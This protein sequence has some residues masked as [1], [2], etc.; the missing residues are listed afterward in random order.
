MSV[1]P[2][3]SPSNSTGSGQAASPE[4]VLEIDASCRAPVLLLFVSALVWLFVGSIFGIIATL[5]FHN[6]N[7][8]A[9][10]AWLTYGRVH[11]AHMNALVYGFA[12]QAGLGVALWLVAHLGRT[13]LAFGPAIMFGAKLWNLGMTLGILGILYGEST[14]YE[15]LEMP[16]YASAF[17]FCGYVLMALG[18]LLTLHQRREGSL[19]ISQTFV[20]AALFWFPWIYSTA[21]LLLVVKPVRG[22]LQAGLDYWYANNLMNIWFGFIGLA[23][24]FYFIP[25]I[26]KRPLYS[27][28]IGI[29]IFWTL[30]L[31]GSWGGIPEGTPLPA[32][33]S[34]M[35]TMGTMLTVVPVLA[36]AYNMLRTM[37]C[38]LPR[39]GES[40]SFSF[41]HF[42]VKSYLVAGLIG[43]LMATIRVGKV[44]NFTWF[45][46]AHTQLFLYGFFAMTMFGAVYYIVP[47]L[48]G[49]EFP[50]PGL[51]TLHL[52]L[53]GGGILFYVVPLM[54]GG[55]KQGLDLN[56]STRT[57]S[58]VTAS[59]LM[60][61]RISTLGDA[62]MALGHLVMLLN[63]VGLLVSVGRTVATTAWTSNTKAVEVAS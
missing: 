34:A 18:G 54:I 27:H 39:W 37:M 28:Y 29:F 47:R 55:V 11:P 46:P 5:K 62:L 19:Y 61:L 26:V 14:G 21:S 42:G 36:F 1:I 9:D 16:R 32:W 31:F 40:K 48:V 38:A 24:I 33:M 35:S 44:T 2:P 59:S 51:I 53:A 23:A 41:F 52:F 13:K 6:T 45:V 20:I 25:K 17:L 10:C 3:Q 30:A 49:A 60:F 22:A 43:A 15:W 7:L 56:D 57:F 8:L 63:V 12:A 58:E 50:K 4:S